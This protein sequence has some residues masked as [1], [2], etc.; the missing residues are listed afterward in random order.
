MNWKKLLIWLG[1]LAILLGIIQYVAWMVFA[2]AG[3]TF[4]GGCHEPEL[5]C[6]FLSAGVTILVL[7]LILALLF[8]DTD[9]GIRW[10]RIRQSLINQLSDLQDSSFQGTDTSDQGTTY[11]EETL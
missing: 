2:C 6:S 4:A 9:P 1:L 8:Y 3:C 7:G 5:K 10:W 11:R